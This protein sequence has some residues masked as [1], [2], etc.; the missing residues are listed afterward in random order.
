MLR[1]FL[2]GFVL[3]LFSVNLLSSN[4]NHGD[5]LFSVSSFIGNYSISDSISTFPYIQ[6][7]ED[8]Q[9]WL[10]GGQNSSWELGVP[11]NGFINSASEGQ[12][13][14]VTGLSSPYNSYEK[15]WVES[16][17]FNFSNLV[18]PSIS[19]D[20][21]YS[22]EEFEDGVCFEYSLD[23]GLSWLHIGANG[24][25][26]NWYNSYFIANLFM[27]N[28]LHGWTGN[29]FNI[30]KNAIHDLSFL[31]GESSVKFRFYFGASQNLNYLEGFAFDNVV[32]SDLMDYDVGISNLLYPTGDCVLSDSENII[33]EITNFGIYSATNFLVSYSFN[34]GSEI[35][36]NFID[37][38]LSDSSIALTFG[39]PVDLTTTG[40]NTVFVSSYL[41]GDQAAYN[42]TATF[43]VDLL[44]PLALPFFEDFESGGIPSGWSLSQ[45]GGSDGWLI[46][47]DLGSTYFDIPVHTT[48]A[49]SNDDTCYC[50]MSNDM[51]ITPAFDLSLYSSVSL[52]FDA[53]ISGFF[54][55]SGK[56]L[57]STDCG[58]S[59][60]NVQ[61][62]MAD[63]FYWQTHTIDLS[64][65]VG[66]SSVKLA[67]HHNDN[68][69]WAA[70][71]AIDN[72]LLNG[73]LY[74]ETQLVGLREGW[75][76]MSTYID[77]V[78][79]SIDSVFSPVSSNLILLKDG[80]GN[81]YWP[82]YELNIIGDHIVGKGY[83]YN[84]IQQDSVLII[85][86]PVLPES[87]IINLPLDWSIIGYV[88]NAEALL[89][90]MM[91]PINTDISI[92]KDDD[93]SA[94]WP[95]YNLN[96]IGMMKPGKGYFIKMY[97]PVIFSYPAN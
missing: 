64:A 40:V 42:D 57:I 29:P 1:S 72:V 45:E 65:Y 21:L 14:W 26:D 75:G 91:M 46:G 33:I 87:T 4:K 31:G 23:N 39:I 13:A 85:G 44:D 61:Y 11:N 32:I 70:G 78:E 48:Y 27:T 10:S 43:L 8:S 58:Y 20:I 67:F 68:G 71:F 96:M 59:W 73:D 84:M 95:S 77:P 49:A 2:I 66:F 3:I 19:F 37:T 24:D 36:E 5:C 93:G 9:L 81:V 90:V 52:Q 38:L 17:T 28:S 30:W 82:Y 12:K 88:R 41:T 50:D 89:D 92:M 94:F 53:Y 51:L 35:Y 7:F 62:V 15:S 76:L 34:G 6:S 97:N 86:I 16:P 83:Q 63:T 55:S 56:I 60:D 47:T 80:N 25:P 74:S 54:G 22:C 69:G 79:P 18:F